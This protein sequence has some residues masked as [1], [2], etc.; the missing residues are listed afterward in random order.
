MPISKLAVS[1][2]LL[3]LLEPVA[4]A[5]DKPNIVYILVDNWGWG[6]ISAQ[7]GTVPTPRIDT[8]ASQ[9]TRFYKLQCP[10]PVHA[11]SLGDPHGA[12]TDPIRQS[13]SA[14]AG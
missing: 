2:L 13:E 6:D 14:R 1:I 3:C 5:Q 7:G 4:S 10:K 8:L 9:G 12:T 11:H